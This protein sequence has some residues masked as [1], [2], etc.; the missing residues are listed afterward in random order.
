[1]Q[2]IGQF[3]NDGK[4]LPLTLLLSCEFGRHMEKVFEFQ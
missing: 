2:A 3:R 4:K 1:M